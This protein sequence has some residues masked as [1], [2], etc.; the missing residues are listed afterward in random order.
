[1]LFH[2]DPNSIAMAN[3]DAHTIFVGLDMQTALT[4]VLRAE[5][6]RFEGA[7]QI[8]AG[9]R[10]DTPGSWAYTPWFSIGDAEHR[11]EVEWEAASAPGQNNGR[12]KL[13]IDG[14][15]RVDRTTL[16]NDT[17]RID[18]ARLGAVAGV[19]T[20]TRGTYYFDQFESYRD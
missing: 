6:R 5:L 18:T 9:A 14:L 11:I 3:L 16:D 8:R 13:K 2:F 4:P 17:L 15:V 10:N 19:D 12:L 1:M 20:G 7:Y